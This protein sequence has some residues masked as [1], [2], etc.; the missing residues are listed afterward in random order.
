MNRKHN[1]PRKRTMPPPKQI[2]GKREAYAVS[3]ETSST[4]GGNGGD[5]IMERVAVLE[6]KVGRIETDISEMR[7]DVKSIDTRLTRLEVKV[8]HL[9]SKGWVDT[10]LIFL[11]GALGAI[12]TFQ[13]QIQTW[14]GL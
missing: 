4:S 8:D 7:S 3:S 6:N 5:G 14:L 1:L 13:N 2:L 9:P 11:L 12:I 10:R